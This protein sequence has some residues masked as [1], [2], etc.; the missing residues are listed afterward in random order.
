[1]NKIILADSQAIF[2]AGTAKVLAMGVLAV[3]RRLRPAADETKR[4][5]DDH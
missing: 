1:M 4:Q 3:G 2:R 5:P